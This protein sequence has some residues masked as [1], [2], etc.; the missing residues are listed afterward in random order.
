MTVRREQRCCLPD[1]K[2]SEDGL[3]YWDGQQWV[4]TL[5]ND[6][7][8]RWNGMSW[9]PVAP[10]GMPTNYTQPH[11]GARTATNWTKPLQY[12]VIAFYAVSALWAIVEPFLMAGSISDYVNQAIQRNAALNPNVPPPPADVIAMINSVTSV[13]LAIGS[14][15]SVAISAIAI[16]GA[17]RRWTWVFYAVL[18]LLGLQAVSSPFTLISAFTSSAISPL[19]LPVGLTAASVALAIPAIALFAWMAVAAF[20]RGPWA[21]TRAPIS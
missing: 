15:I 18:V 17:V 4:S 3:Y 1:L 12:S 21:M 20:R 16:I 11:T 7:R 10:T 14:A 2:L 9:V 19:K 5:S 13:A 8:S 6:G